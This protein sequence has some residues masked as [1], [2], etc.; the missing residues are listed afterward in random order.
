[1]QYSFAIYQEEIFERLGRDFLNDRDL[2][3]L[4]Q[5]QADGALARVDMSLT[6][7][8]KATANRWLQ[9]SMLSSVV[10]LQHVDEDTGCFLLT[11]PRSK[12]KKMSFLFSG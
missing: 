10:S 2:S 6:P 11:P 3:V 8:V 7:V 5:E 12:E 9:M 1:L 4:S